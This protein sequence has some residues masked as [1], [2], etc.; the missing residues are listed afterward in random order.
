MCLM[1]IGQLK[2]NLTDQ[3][4]TG[5]WPS[6]SKGRDFVTPGHVATS[7]YYLNGWPWSWQTFPVSSNEVVTHAIVVWKDRRSCTNLSSHVTDC[8]HPCNT[9]QLLHLLR[10]LLLLLLQLQLMLLLLL[11]IL[12]LL[13][14]VA[15]SS[16]VCRVSLWLRTTTVAHQE[17][18][19]VI[20]YFTRKTW[21]WIN[22]VN[23]P[24]FPKYVTIFDREILI[25]WT[26]QCRN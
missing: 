19:Q 15:I 7:G 3:L 14:I 24:F 2:T 10:R 20:S 1:H 22:A 25:I 13:Q 6:E 12:I 21:P 26:L 5:N 17:N 18:E 4:A 8:S 11:L 16:T 9:Q 23:L